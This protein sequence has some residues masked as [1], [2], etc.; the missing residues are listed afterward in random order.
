VWLTDAAG[1][2]DPA[3][4]AYVT[5]TVPASNG[6]PG[7]NN[8]TS[9]GAGSNEPPSSGNT[10]PNIPIHVTE[11]LRGRRLVV[12]VTGPSNGLLRIVVTGR[13][14]GRTVI[15]E[16]TV[17]RIHARLTAIFGLP[18]KIARHAKITVTVILE[19]QKPVSSTLC[20]RADGES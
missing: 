15:L 14:R 5:L 9:G 4:A 1:N 10:L 11:K 7:S 12:S 2:S 17:S 8:G 13:Y 18:D 16:R 19:H 3:N 6:D 20:R